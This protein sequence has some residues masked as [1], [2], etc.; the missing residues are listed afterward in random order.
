MP[1][2]VERDDE[3]RLRIQTA[4]GEITGAEWLAS[5]EQQ[6]ADGTWGYATLTDASAV[7]SIPTTEEVYTFRAAVERLT[8]QFGQRG[9]RAFVISEP[10]ALFGVARM[11]EMTTEE[12]QSVY[13]CHTRRAAED[14]LA[15]KVRPT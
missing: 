7:T 10:S 5:L 1:I 9:P 4:A 14:W 8:Q 6:A 11:Y 13:V 2:T 3:R 12:M 15:S